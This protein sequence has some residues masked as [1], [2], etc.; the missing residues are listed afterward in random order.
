MR[1]KSLS[2]LEHLHNKSFKYSFH[3]GSS[4]TVMLG[5]QATWE[6]GEG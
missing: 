3:G 1:N 2:V 5:V 6:G 4:D